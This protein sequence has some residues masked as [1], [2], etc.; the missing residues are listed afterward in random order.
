MKKFYVVIESN[1]LDLDL[2]AKALTNMNHTKFYSI[3]AA[4]IEKN[5]KD[6][7]L[8]CDCHILEVVIDVKKV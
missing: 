1:N 4:Q 6:E 3:E 5:R 8:N 2:E 7:D